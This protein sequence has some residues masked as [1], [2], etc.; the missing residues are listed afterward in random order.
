MSY[1]VEIA[2]AS[3]DVTDLMDAIASYGRAR[4]YAQSLPKSGLRTANERAAAADSVDSQ[5]RISVPQAIESL[6]RDV[7]EMQ[8]PAT[9]ATLPAR[10]H[11]TSQPRPTTRTDGTCR[12]THRFGHCP[13]GEHDHRYVC[14]EHQ[15]RRDPKGNCTTCAASTFAGHATCITCGSFVTHTRTPNGDHQCDTCRTTDSALIAHDLLHARITRDS[16]L[17]TVSLAT[18]DAAPLKKLAADRALVICDSCNRPT[19]A[20][21]VVKLDSSPPHSL[22]ICDPLGPASCHAQLRVILADRIAESTP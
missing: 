21:R 11:T 5:Y 20:Y 7:I 9:T 19:N 1:V 10:I 22:T 4:E 17:D 3:I 14:V 8:L 18:W 13:T 12:G 2:G 16:I 15:T 6:I